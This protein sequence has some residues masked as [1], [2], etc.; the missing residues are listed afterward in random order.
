MARKELHRG[1]IRR[2][3]IGH[4]EA[5]PA[6]ADNAPIR[7]GPALIETTMARKELYARTIGRIAIRH[8]QT[9]SPDTNDPTIDEVPLLVKAT[10]AMEN[11]HRSAIRRIA[12]RDVQ[13]GIADACKQRSLRH[14]Q[15]HSRNQSRNNR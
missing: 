6:N 13:A 4:I 15:C 5:F 9:F 12:I 3:A 11:L 1:A 7:Y 2:I 10:M 8:I 14:T